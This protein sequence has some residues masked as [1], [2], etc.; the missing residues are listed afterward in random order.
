MFTQKDL[1][2]SKWDITDYLD[3]EEAI[4]AYIQEVIEDGDPDLMI[5]AIGNVA[6]AKGMSALANEMGVKRESLYKSLSGKSKPQFET[7]YK[8]LS[9]LGLQFSVSPKHAN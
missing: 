1:E 2:T 5:K 8:A 9:A 4:A 6:K 7:I 3:S